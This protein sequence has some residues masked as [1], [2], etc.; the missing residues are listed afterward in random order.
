MYHSKE[1]I[2]IVQIIDRDQ[3]E[4]ARMRD[5]HGVVRTKEPPLIRYTGPLATT[6]Y[7]KLEKVFTGLYL[8]PGHERIQQLSKRILHESSISPDIKVLA[9]C[10]KA[11]SV[12]LHKNYKHAEEVLAT[13]FKIASN[14]E[15]E[16]S[17]LLQG[18]VLRHLA[19]MQYAQHYDDKALEYMSGAKESLFLASPSNETAFAVHTELLVKSRRLFSTPASFS[20]EQ[21]L[22]A[23]R[24]YELLL[25]HA[26]YM[27]EYEQPLICSF[28]AV[29][30][31]FHLRSAL[32]K[33]NLPPEEYWPTPD[34]LRKAEEC[35]NRVSLDAMPDQSNFYT[36]QYYRTC[37]DL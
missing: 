1:C 23:E 14:L 34:D 4:E 26:E 5:Q 2:C 19:F 21:F 22:S 15:C 35:L 29:K 10:W 8:S 30:A 12:A 9:L 25:K 24:D 17:S 33:D 37:C 27:E 6:K 31:S 11:L 36:A 3:H 20:S 13:A 16:N 28:H 7:H 18:R 32:I